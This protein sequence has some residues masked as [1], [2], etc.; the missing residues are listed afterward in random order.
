M[1]ASSTPPTTTEVPAVS[2]TANVFV[3]VNDGNQLLHGLIPGLQFWSIK[4]QVTLTKYRFWL[5]FCFLSKHRKYFCFFNSFERK[6]KARSVT[7]FFFYMLISFLA[8][9][10]HA[11]QYEH[12]GLALDENKIYKFFVKKACFSLICWSGIY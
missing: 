11:L 1:P 7:I 3:G 10:S 4:Q 2:N 6:V 5:F 8:S 9:V 12:V